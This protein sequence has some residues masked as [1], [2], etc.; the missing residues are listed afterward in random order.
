MLRD[1]LAHISGFNQVQGLKV[2]SS[3]EVTLK[4]EMPKVSWHGLRKD[5]FT[6]S[7]EGSSTF[8]GLTLMKA[9]GCW[10]QQFLSEAL[11]IEKK[12]IIELGRKRFK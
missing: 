8:R 12:K 10:Y 6:C 5:R 9:R 3:R 7:G 1:S 2:K 4:S 11:I